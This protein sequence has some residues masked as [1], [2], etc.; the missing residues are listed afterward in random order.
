MPIINDVSENENYVVCLDEDRVR[1]VS[2][3]YGVVTDLP[4]HIAETLAA[5]IMG[6]KWTREEK[7]ERNGKH[8]LI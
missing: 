3:K 8:E 1:V 2:P 5:M 4:T 6:A 7:R